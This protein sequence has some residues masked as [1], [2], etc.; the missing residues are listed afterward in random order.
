MQ[1]LW[2]NKFI[3]SLSSSKTHSGNS[4]IDGKFKFEKLTKETTYI[5]AVAN[6]ENKRFLWF[7]ELDL[8]SKNQQ[9]LSDINNTVIEVKNLDKLLEYFNKAIS[10]NSD[11]APVK[12]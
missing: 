9:D 7:V 11:S 12:N 1:S 5:F 8:S 2:I 10:V 3:D 4:N 6:H